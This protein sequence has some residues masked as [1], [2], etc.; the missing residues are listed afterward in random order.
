MEIST[1]DVIRVIKIRTAADYMKHCV[2]AKCICDATSL[3]RGYQGMELSCRTIREARGQR[4]GYVIKPSI[5]QRQI[6]STEVVEG[7]PA[8]TTKGILYRT[9][10]VYCLSFSNISR[11]TRPLSPQ[12]KTKSHSNESVRQSHIKTLRARVQQRDPLIVL[13]MVIMVI[14]T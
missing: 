10:K 12:E 8:T 9:G 13:I 6:A 2:N 3:R 14:S 7:R 5:E 4:S 1:R 11:R